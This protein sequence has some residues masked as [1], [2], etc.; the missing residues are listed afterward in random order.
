MARFESVEAHYAQKCGRVQSRQAADD[1]S[2]VYGFPRTNT[3][4]L[5]SVYQSPQLFERND[6][7]SLAVGH[8]VAVRADWSQIS[9]R[10]HC[11]PAGFSDGP[12][13][14]DLDILARQLGPVEFIEVEPAHGALRPVDL[15]SAGAVAWAA[16]IRDVLAN[17]ASAFGVGNE[18]LVGDAVRALFGSDRTYGG[19]LCLPG[20]EHE[21]TRLRRFRV[22][23]KQVDLT[24]VGERRVMSV[25]VEQVDLVA[26][27][28]RAYDATVVALV[29]FALPVKVVALE[30]I[31]VLREGFL[32]LLRHEEHNDVLAGRG[33]YSASDRVPVLVTPKG[34]QFRTVVLLAERYASKS[35]VAIVGRNRSIASGLR[36][37]RRRSRTLGPRCA[38]V[39]RDD[40]FL[41]SRGSGRNG[42]PELAGSVREALG[43]IL[44][45]PGVHGWVSSGK[46]G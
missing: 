31:L 27:R 18:L 26:S 41:P 45:D 1:A 42:A 10:V 32:L 25:A 30:M 14:V 11:I 3:S 29:G 16:L 6:T 7:P 12:C 44:G 38:L 34:R 37:I 36:Q 4:S 33:D 43:G 39:R 9:L 2:R 35:N 22:I 17:D 24:V 46:D 23:R 5:R 20:G 40:S 21:E 8:A 28:L 15:Q 13:M 19:C